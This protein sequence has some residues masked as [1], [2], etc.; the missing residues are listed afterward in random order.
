[1]RV[2]GT[3]WLCAYGS[4]GLYWTICDKL[5]GLLDGIDPT[6]VRNLLPSLCPSTA[7]AEI[8][9]DRLLSPRPYYRYYHLKQ[10]LD[11]LRPLGSFSY[12]TLNGDSPRNDT[13]RLLATVWGRE[14]FG[15]DG[16][17]R[18]AV[19][20]TSPHRAPVTAVPGTHGDIALITQMRAGTHFV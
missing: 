10:V 3:L 11:I 1:T 14:M 15:P 12:A 2:G 17:I 8:F 4:G 9:A 18:I 20:K 6:S 16:E 7:L 5:R 19:T 13:A